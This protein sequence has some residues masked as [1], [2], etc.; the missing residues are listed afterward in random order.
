MQLDILAFAA[1]PDDTELSCSGTLA[2][3]VAKGRAVGV[4][5]LTRGE[6]GTRGTIETRAEEAAAS[7]ALLGL[8]VREN[9]GFE[10]ALFQKDKEHLTEVVK[11]IRKY[12]PKIILANAIRDRHPDHGRAA[13]LIREA[14]F[15]S[16]LRKFITE[17]SGVGQEAWRPMAVYHYV[18]SIYVKPDIVVDISD[19]WEIKQQAIRCFKTQFFN[20]ESDEPDT[21][22]SS[23]GF[24]K[25][26]EGRARE[27]GFVIGAEFAEGFT[28]DRYIGVKSLFDLM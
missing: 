1:H 18:Q 20:P 27:F 25:F 10:D 4:V 11:K 2:S 6:M 22:I 21:F 7:S 8:A 28:T 23:E 26:L 5:D 12:R 17:E 24:L 13:D 15:L 19:F 3:H 16:G 9:L 14:C